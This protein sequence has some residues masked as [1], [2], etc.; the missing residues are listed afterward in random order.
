MICTW[1][2]R[3]K[4][5]IWIRNTAVIDTGSRNRHRRLL[6][7]A[8]HF[9]ILFVGFCSCSGSGESVLWSFSR[10]EILISSNFKVLGPKIMLTILLVFS[11]WFGNL[12]TTSIIMILYILD[13][14]VFRYKDL[15]EI[16]IMIKDRL[17]KA[18][19][20][21]KYYPM[22]KILNKYIGNLVL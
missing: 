4:E 12:G 5:P 9:A 18:G 10:I 11:I 19:K 3:K 21:H 13:T 20:I 17:I 6:F 22:N 2:K 16:F 7:C 15:K 1:S 14:L 8:G